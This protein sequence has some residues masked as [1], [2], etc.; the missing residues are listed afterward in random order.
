MQLRRHKC[1]PGRFI[2]EAAPRFGNLC[3]YEPSALQKK[4]SASS[5]ES[6]DSRKKPSDLRKK[7]SDLRRELHCKRISEKRSECWRHF[8]LTCTIVWPMGR[9]NSTIK[10]VSVHNIWKCHCTVTVIMV[11][12]ESSLPLPSKCAPDTYL[13]G[14]I[15]VLLWVWNL[16]TGVYELFNISDYRI[17]YIAFLQSL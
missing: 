16:L 1:S 5:E 11:C 6:F 10:W 17:R 4:P 15:F 7:P 9:L 3:V 12:S 14:I 2:S 8:F 13:H